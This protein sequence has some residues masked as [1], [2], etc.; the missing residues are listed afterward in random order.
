[1]RKIISLAL[2]VSLLFFL[3]SAGWAQAPK[4][5]EQLVYGLNVFNGRGYGGGFVPQSEDTIYLIAEKD[6]A[7]SAH[8]TLVYFWPIT[9]RYMAAWQTLNEEVEGTLEVLKEGKVIKSLKKRDNCLYYPEGY[10][11]ETSILYTDEEAIKKFEEYKKAVEKFY[12]AVSDY[13]KKMAEYKKKLDKFLEET[14]KLR[15]AGEKLSPEEV[16]KMMP[17]EPK[18]PEPPGFYVT[19]PRKDYIV[20]LPVGTYRIRIRAEDGTIVQD[21]EKKLVVFTS[22]RRGGVGYEII[23]GN[24]WTR[25]E[26]CD[27]PARIIYAAGKNTLYFRPFHQDEY[28]ELYYNKLEDPQNFGRE[29]RWRWVHI[30]P[31]KDVLLAFLKEGRLIK[32]VK[33]LPYYVKQIPGPE[34]GYNIIEYKKEEMPDRRPTFEGYKLDLSPELAKGRYEI[35]LEKKLEKGKFLEGGTRQIRLVRKE[36]SKYLYPFSIFPLVVGIVVF[37]GR[38]IKTR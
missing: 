29:E 26:S 38:K 24:R 30:K 9:A 17:K 6:N 37:I 7:I 18:E 20:N 33:N 16:E 27:D 10:W 13:Y 14:K 36:S 25:R 32:K 23:P 8:M 28:N 5:K 12:K 31:I 22:R 2:L 34:L 11:S 3:S 19:E 4:M 1:M 15:E 21:S 35:K